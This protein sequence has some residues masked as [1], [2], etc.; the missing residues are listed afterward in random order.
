[1]NTPPFTPGQLVKNSESSL[2]PL[3]DAYNNA[4]DSQGKS[5]AKQWLADRIAE[6]AIIIDCKP[7]KYCAWEVEYQIVGRNVTG[8][9]LPYLWEAVKQ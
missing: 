3:R 2:K 7:G 6:R 8:K 1:M 9:S 5:R 4:G